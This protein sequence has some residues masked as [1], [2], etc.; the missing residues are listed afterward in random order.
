MPGWKTAIQEGFKL[1]GFGS[2]IYTGSFCSRT[3]FDYKASVFFLFTFKLKTSSYTLHLAS[4]ETISPFQSLLSHT[5]VIDAFRFSI[6][7]FIAGLQVIYDV[8]QSLK[9]SVGSTAHQHALT[10]ELLSLEKVLAEIKALCPEICECSQLDLLKTI[11]NQ[12]Q[13]TI[14]QFYLKIKKYQPNLTPGGSGSLYKGIFRKI[15]WSLCEK[16]DIERFCKEIAGYVRLISMVLSM[17]Q[18]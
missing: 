13:E 8:V 12:C 7:D 15:K 5:K 14:H 17:L 18:L 16:G 3:S 2:Q 9:S 10:Q 4:S 1:H 11:T 6:G